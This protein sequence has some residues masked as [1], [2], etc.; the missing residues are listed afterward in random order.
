LVWLGG[1]AHPATT[2]LPLAAAGPH[3]VFV[4]ARGY[5]T[6]IGFRIADLAGPLAQ[7]AQAFPGAQTILVGFGDRT[8]ITTRDKWLGTWLLTLLPGKGAMLVTALPG[9]PEA[10]FGASHVVRLHLT[11]LQFARVLGFVNGSFA[12]AQGAPHFI[13]TG[14]Y[15]GS[16]FYD[17]ARTYDLLD[18]CNTWTAAALANAGLNV[19][20]TFTLFARQTM[21]AARSV[22]RQSSVVGGSPATGDR[23]PT[24]DY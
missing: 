4:D 17:S 13:G 16:R 19:P 20:V 15:L 5:H 3:D 7:A 23:R 1:C 11:G 10:A 8:F 9:D 18:T 14:P 24:K 2:P 12:L 21:A 6:D 22:G